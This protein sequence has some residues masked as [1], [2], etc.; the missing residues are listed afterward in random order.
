MMSEMKWRLLTAASMALFPAPILAQ[1]EPAADEIRDGEA[2]AE[3]V[4]TATRR[5]STLQSVGAPI[6]VISGAQL[7]RAGASRFEDYILAVPS[8]SFRDQGNGATRLALRGISNVAGADSG[9]GSTV[10]TVGL[11]LGDIP[12]QGTSVLPDLAIYDL[13]RVEVLKGPQGTLYGEGAVG[14]AVR[15]LPNPVRLSRFEGSAE[16]AGFVPE[17]GDFGWRARGALN[18]PI[19]ADHLGVRLVASYRNEG[20]F[21]D[22][23]RTGVNDANS[24]EGYSV[25]A[26]LRAEPTD[27]LALEVFGMVNRDRLD[28]FNQVNSLLGDLQN[29]L[30]ERQYNLSRMKLFAGTINYDFGAA[31]LT[32]VTSYG[33]FDRN[34]RV[35]FPALGP[36]LRRFGTVTAEPENF[37]VDQRTITQETRL[38]S[39]GD[40]RFDWV[41]GYFF[42]DRRSLSYISIDLL[43]DDL[44]S[45]NSGLAALNLATFPSEQLVVSHIDDFYKQHAVYGE[46]TY[47]ITDT[48]D[49]TIGLRWFVERI[50]FRSSTDS[51]SILA[52]LRNRN[53]GS[54][55]ERGVIPRFNL[56]WRPSRSITAYAQVAKGFRSGGVNFQA[57]LGAGEPTYGSDNLWNYELGLKT[58]FLDGQVR[59]NLAAYRTDWS[60]IQSNFFLF[61]P[62]LNLDLGLINNGGVARI[63]GLEGEIFVQPVRGLTFSA[64]AAYL[65]AKLKEPAPGS[66]IIAGQQLPNAPAV[67]FATS[68]EYRSSVG[69]NTSAWI[70]ADYQFTDKQR[71]RFATRTFDGFPLDAYGIANA[72]VGLDIDSHTIQ[73]F[74]QN[75]FD[76]RGQLGQGLSLLT[77]TAN[78]EILTITRPRTI[79]VQFSSHW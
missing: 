65:D 57:A 31:Q 15:F 52:S 62:A 46:G 6:Q 77:N 67:T 78:P 51:S 17:A 26:T 16:L 38:V 73:L 79:G 55:I 14:G 58:S 35:R 71:L 49:L 37:D 18:L 3:I 50:H 8:V 56:T 72:R 33:T 68:G 61:L 60:D 21:I 40:N 28:D 7:D 25:R 13:Q 23:I 29:N 66:N 9:A 63:Y 5:E 74:V 19:I 45:V 42:R 1:E 30:A 54:L 69:E 4:V 11:Y 34:F 39:V 64:N 76:T 75:I 10:S 53:A 27:R 59:A 32:S 24:A 12:I 2:P 48:L 70:K 41:L 20:G 43:P 47:G 36:I 44:A 22:N